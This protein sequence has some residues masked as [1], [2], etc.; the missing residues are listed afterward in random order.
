MLFKVPINLEVHIGTVFMTSFMKT[1][2]SLQIALKF[3]SCIIG[4]L[5]KNVSINKLAGC[6]SYIENRP[7]SGVNAE[8]K[9]IIEML[10][11]HSL[12]FI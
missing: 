11:E 9:V 7:Q 10:Q 2:T 5:Y 12:L 8:D 4:P 3:G 1:R 6:V